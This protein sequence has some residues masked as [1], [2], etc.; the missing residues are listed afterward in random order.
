MT[1]QSVKV[2]VSGLINRYLFLV[3]INDW[4]IENC[5]GEW[6]YKKD[7]LNYNGTIVNIVDVT[8][9]V[10]QYPSDAMAFKLRWF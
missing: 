3:S 7:C 6:W 4:L 9:Y 8:H 1:E 10:F 2:D 5:N